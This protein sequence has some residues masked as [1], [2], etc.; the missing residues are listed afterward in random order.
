MFNKYYSFTS[1]EEVTYILFTAFCPK[2]LTR[3]PLF[4]SC[5]NIAWWR[6]RTISKVSV[7]SAESKSIN[8]RN[9][10]IFKRYKNTA[11]VEIYLGTTGLWAGPSW[12]PVKSSLAQLM[13]SRRKNVIFRIYTYISFSSTYSR[14]IPSLVCY[15]IQKIEIK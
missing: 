12:A 15:L 2:K 7:V 4:E 1:P 6:A 9:H 5:H 14:G 13:P 8:S 11:R 10:S 3:V